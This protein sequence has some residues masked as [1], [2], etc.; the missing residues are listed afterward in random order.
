MV[1]TS[2]PGLLHLHLS[3]PLSC[4]ALAGPLTINPLV[5]LPS[6]ALSICPGQVV[7]KHINL[8]RGPTYLGLPFGLRGWSQSAQ[9]GLPRVWKVG[10]IWVW[11][12]SLFVP[13]PLPVSF[14][15]PSPRGHTEELKVTYAMGA[16]RGTLI[17]SER[18]ELSKRDMASYSAR[19]QTNKT[20]VGGKGVLSSSEREA[21]GTWFISRYLQSAVSPLGSRCPSFLSP[22]AQGRR[23][24]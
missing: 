21:E 1:S 4:K 23:G 10:P 19:R 13:C 9:R 5:S 17:N 7:G 6:T 15:I 3:P 11:K 12:R 22:A 16:G 14:P 2:N 20:Q 18:A 24:P 8:G